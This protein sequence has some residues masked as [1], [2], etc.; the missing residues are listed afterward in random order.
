MMNIILALLG[1]LP[2]NPYA[3]SMYNE[4]E[5][6]QKT[7]YTL[8]HKN[9]AEIWVHFGCNTYPTTNVSIAWK[10]QTM[11]AYSWWSNNRPVHK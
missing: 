5:A 9:G 10:I 2:L 7:E 11:R 4:P 8:K 1:K 3:E 6:W